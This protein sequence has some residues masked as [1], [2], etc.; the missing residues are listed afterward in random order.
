[1]LTVT[2]ARRA[3]YPAATHVLPPTTDQNPTP[4]IPTMTKA[5]REMENVGRTAGHGPYKCQECGCESH[6]RPA[7]SFRPRVA[8]FVVA[9][10]AGGDL[11][12]TR[13]ARSFPMRSILP[14]CESIRDLTLRFPIHRADTQR[15]PPEE[16]VLAPPARAAQGSRDDVQTLQRA[17]Q[18]REEAGAPQVARR[19]A[20]QAQEQRRDPQQGRAGAPVHV[21]LR[22]RGVGQGPPH[23]QDILTKHSCVFTKRHDETICSS[24]TRYARTNLT[25]HCDGSS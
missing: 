4:T 18:V 22:S 13:R 5:H 3:P 11:R 6:F 25:A 10:R 20:Q 15:D 9:T 12:C 23:R 2:L 21:P 14:K 19:G 1:M 17:R 24:K 7:P 16:G 8:S